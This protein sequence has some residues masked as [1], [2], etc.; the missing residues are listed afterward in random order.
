MRLELQFSE[1]TYRKQMQLLYEIG[2]GKKKA[3]YKNAHYFGFVFVGLGALAVAG[4]ANIGYLFI[5][6]GLVVLI[7]YYRFYFIQKKTAQ[8]YEAEQLKIINVFNQKPD[9]VLEFCEE[10]LS[11]TNYSGTIKIPWNTFTTFTIKEEN[12]FLI[13]RDFRPFVLGKSEIGEESY[14]EVIKFIVLKMGK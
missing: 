5:V 9:A 10:D 4:R 2:Y 6:L 13:T 11:Y 7:S 8:E 3:Y 1:P 12:L 14:N